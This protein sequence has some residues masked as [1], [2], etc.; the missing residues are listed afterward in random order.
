VNDQS[1]VGGA[2]Q[3]RAPSRCAPW[4]AVHSEAHPGTRRDEL[5]PAEE[6][7]IRSMQ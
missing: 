4:C 6:Q 1:L 5:L 7:N 2:L 3:R